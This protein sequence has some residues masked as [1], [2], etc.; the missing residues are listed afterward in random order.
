MTSD[1]L[2]TQNVRTLQN[3]VRSTWPWRNSAA[4]G[5]KPSCDSP[6]LSHSIHFPGLVGCASMRCV[7]KVF[8][9]DGSDWF[10]QSR[11]VSFDVDVCVF[12]VQ[13]CTRVH[14][15]H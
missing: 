1:P 13:I 12:T 15:Q 14:A 9:D 5:S 3:A 2:V 4:V 8:A 7:L 6:S 10:P 11:R